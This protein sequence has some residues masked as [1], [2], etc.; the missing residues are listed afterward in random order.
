M[1]KSVSV[2]SLEFQ[3]DSVINSPEKRPT[4]KNSYPWKNVLLSTQKR[5]IHGKTF[6]ASAG[7]SDSGEDS[8]S[9]NGFGYA[10][11]RVNFR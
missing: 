2:D 3:T 5:F 7:L 10:N 4:G 11:K 1:K 8:P 9:K 6:S